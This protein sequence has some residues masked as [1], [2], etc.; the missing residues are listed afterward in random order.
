MV[1]TGPTMTRGEASAPPAGIFSLHPRPCAE[2]L[3]ACPIQ[4]LSH[5]GHKD[6]ELTIGDAAHDVN[7]HV[8]IDED[9]CHSLRIPS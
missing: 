5:R 7:Q 4:G 1:G 3:I 6:C 2:D 9:P 8:R